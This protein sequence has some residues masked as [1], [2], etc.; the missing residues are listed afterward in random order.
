[1]CH[2]LRTFDQHT[3][4]YYFYNTP[5]K[6]SDFIYKYLQGLVNTELRVIGRVKGRNCV[7]RDSKFSYKHLYFSQE[8]QATS[9]LR[10]L[11]PAVP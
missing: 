10:T 3:V 1:M 2:V 11:A 9:N 6:H 7:H 8:H 5:S 4:S